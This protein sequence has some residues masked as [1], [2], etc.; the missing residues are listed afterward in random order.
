MP[1]VLKSG[2]MSCLDTVSIS[3]VRSSIT[4][5][6]AADLVENLIEQVLV[7]YFEGFK[8]RRTLELLYS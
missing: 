8:D 6:N 5:F 1:S 3:T 2:Q 4:L 7:K